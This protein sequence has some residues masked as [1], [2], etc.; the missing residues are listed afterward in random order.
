MREAYAFGELLKS[1]RKQQKVDQQS[2]AERLGVHRNTIGKWERGICLPDSRGMVLELS[3][4]LRLSQEETR[5]LLEASLTGLSSYWHISY[6]R[7]PFFT[8]RSMFLHTLRDRLCSKQQ[9]FHNQCYALSGLGGIGK[10]QLALEYAY[11]SALDYQAVFWVSAET[12]NTLTSGFTALAAHLQLPEAREDEYQSIV[13]AVLH[14]L[15]T[16]KD[17]LL[18]FDNVENLAILTPFLPVARRGAVLLTTRLHALDGIAQVLELPPFT[19]EEGC[20]FLLRRAGLIDETCSCESLPAELKEPAYA[21]VDAMEGLPLALDRAGAYIEQT[22][23]SI[24]DFLRLF[25]SSPMKILQERSSHADYSM[26]VSKTLMFSFERVQQKNPAAAELLTC[27]AFLA[28]DEIPESLF[29]TS[30]SHLGPVLHDLLADV[31]GYHA[32]MKDLLAYSL[33]QRHTRTQMLSVHRLVQS[34]LKESQ[35]ECISLEWAR[36]L[37]SALDYAF[38]SYKEF[39]L[40]LEQREWCEKLLPHALSCINGPDVSCQAR[41]SLFIKITDYLLHCRGEYAR[42]EPLLQRA[43]AICEQERGPDHPDTAL[44]LNGLGSLYREQARYQEAEPPLQRALAICE[45]ER[46]PDHPDTAEILNALGLLYGYQGRYTEA[47]PFF[48]RSLSIYEQVLGACHLLTASPLGNLAV[49][50]LRQGRHME[51]EPLFQR[52]LAICEQELGSSHPKVSMHLHNLASIY[53][54]QEK[55]GEA[56]LLYQRALTIREQQLGPMHRYTAM[57]L[58]SLARLYHDQGKYVEA[59]PLYQRAL[60][61]RKQRLGPAHPDTAGSLRSLA[62]LY[63]DQKKWAKAEV[64]YRRALAIYEQKFGSVYP[65]IARS[66][67]GLARLF[68]LQGKYDE[69]VTFAQR[70]LTTWEQIFGAEHPQTKAAR[71]TYERLRRFTNSE[72]IIT[73]QYSGKEPHLFVPQR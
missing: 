57:S 66:L 5:L 11:Q 7:N 30:A 2:L 61:I 32:A 70:A 37:L 35:P 40:T 3:R 23:C 36:R 72:G 1:L 68:E 41:I 59:E 44:I 47:E 27:C 48:R 58:N 6:R 69:A 39:H 51:A 24:R 56:E 71:A 64:L 46:G 62:R 21:L 18:I 19:A 34:V 16:H 50:F 42:V 43:L 45:Q 55:Y 9:S 10:T 49:L 38:P 14:W 60:S 26:S 33:V 63:T 25:L 15:K 31:W 54:D 17:W 8:G 53:H 52:A 29:V 20:I 13:N 4:C 65:D 12:H 73:L 28:P 22:G 67:D